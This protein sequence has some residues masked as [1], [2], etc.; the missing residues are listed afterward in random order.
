MSTKI[1]N[2]SLP[3]ELVKV[4][5]VQAKLHYTTRSEYIKTAIINRLKTDGAFNESPEQTPQNP[6]QQRRAQLKAFLENYEY[7]IEE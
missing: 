5:D 2:L 4:I 1:F 7:D 6:D 3:P